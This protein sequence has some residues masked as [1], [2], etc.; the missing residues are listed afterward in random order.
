MHF[1]VAAIDKFIKIQYYNVLGKIQ[2]EREKKAM[3]SILVTFFNMPLKNSFEASW[4]LA[5]EGFFIS[6]AITAFSYLIIRFKIT[7]DWQRRQ[8]LW[9]PFCISLALGFIV[10]FIDFSYL[11]F[12]NLIP[13]P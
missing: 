5:L 12:N 11:L 3:I 10:V 7:D 6:V 2:S 9:K 4:G 1:F 8:C 13:R